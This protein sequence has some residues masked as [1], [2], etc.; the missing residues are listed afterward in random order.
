MFYWNKT[1]HLHID[2]VADNCQRAPLGMMKI[3]FCINVEIKIQI[4]VLHPKIWKEN[5][6]CRFKGEA[7][8]YIK[9]KKSLFVENLLMAFAMKAN[10][11][12]FN[13]SRKHMLV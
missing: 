5:C 9:S 12:Y 10:K 7:R 6:W 2:N 13:I 3:C 4:G 1:A 8:I 11:I